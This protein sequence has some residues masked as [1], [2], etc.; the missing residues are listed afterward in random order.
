MKFYEHI[1]LMNGNEIESTLDSIAAM[2]NRYNK[3]LSCYL[4]IRQGK[5]VCLEFIKVQAKHIQSTLFMNDRAVVKDLALQLE[6]LTEQ[7]WDSKDVSLALFI[8]QGEEIPMVKILRLKSPVDNQLSL[9]SR[10]DILPLLNMQNGLT[11]RTLLVFIDGRIQIFDVD[12]GIIKPV[13]WASAPHLKNPQQDERKQ[14][15]S[16]PRDKHLH[17]VCLSLLKSSKKPLMIAAQ[18]SEIEIIKS[19]LPKKISW[20]LNEDIILPY[21]VNQT[22]VFAFI[23]KHLLILQQ[24]ETQ[25]YI[26]MLLN[27]MRV[28]G[29]AITG[30]SASINALDNNQV[31]QLMIARTYGHQASWKCQHCGQ[32]MSD[33]STNDKCSCTESAA[34]KPWNPIIEASWLAYHNQVPVFQVDS[35]DLRYLG[36]IGCLLKQRQEADR[37][38][39]KPL[40]YKHQQR[41]AA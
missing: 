26:S 18:S 30:P 41:L 6:Q 11:D 4:D 17:N 9:Y 2:S 20:K 40:E 21:N 8:S 7:S 32:V 10:A 34:I 22:G 28:K 33:L 24:A 36:G 16:A 29:P 13:A 14:I 19:W 31:S 38:P 37:L 27:S 1:K 12:L 23:Q 15:K 39:L 5:D 25:S 35:D 3:V